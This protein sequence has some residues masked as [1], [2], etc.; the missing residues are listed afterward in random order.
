MLFEYDFSG[1]ELMKKMPVT[2]ECL[3][4]GGAWIPRRSFVIVADLEVLYG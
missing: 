1:V 2:H 4:A 3:K